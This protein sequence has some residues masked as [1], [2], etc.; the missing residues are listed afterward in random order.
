[1]TL[2]NNSPIRGRVTTSSSARSCT[3]LQHLS[4]QVPGLTWLTIAVRVCAIRPRFRVSM[5]DAC[6]DQFALAPV[7]GLHPRKFVN[8]VEAGQA[9]R[10]RA[11]FN[12][13]T[14]MHACTLLRAVSKDGGGVMPCLMVHA[15]RAKMC[16]HVN[17][18]GCY[19]AGLYSRKYLDWGQNARKTVDLKLTACVSRRFSLWLGKWT[20][21]NVFPSQVDD[22]VNPR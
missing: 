15:A 14:S 9:K 16:L 10:G 20:T 1:M 5:S 18:R 11:F 19:R 22:N 2:T 13:S 3:V 6:L 4:C 7:P 17:K 8:S 12:L 21:F